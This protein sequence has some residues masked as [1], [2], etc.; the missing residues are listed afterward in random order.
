MVNK[1]GTLGGG[2]LTSH[3]D[4]YKESDSTPEMF[5]HQK[6]NEMEH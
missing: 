6:K 5:A 2:R 4:I 1:G 3:K